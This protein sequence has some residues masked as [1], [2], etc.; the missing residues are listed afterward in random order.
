MRIVVLTGAGASAES[1]LGTFRDAGGVW[2][3]ASLEEVATPEG[4]AA[5]P[6]KVHAF[7]NRRRRDCLAA[8]PNAAHEAL[9]RLV[10]DPRI[11]ALIVTQNVDD[12]HERAGTSGDALIHMHGELLRARCEA[13]GAETLW[14]DDLSTETPCPNCNAQGGMRPAVVWF[15]EMPLQLDRIYD[16]IAQ[17][18]LFV[19]IGTSGQVYPAAGF[20]QLAL[21]AG[22]DTVELNM[23]RTSPSFTTGRLGPAT[24]IVP[25]WVEDVLARAE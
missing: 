18:D 22:A 21:E 6:A 12:L 3:Q 4:F 7:Y 8:K 10:G 9:T 16:E 13:C 24:E 2:T 25:G 23:E 17:A 14:S 20:V 11:D 19:S 1:G 5:N 15:G